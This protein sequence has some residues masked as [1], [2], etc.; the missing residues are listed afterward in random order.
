MEIEEKI[1]AKAEL[2]YNEKIHNIEL[3]RQNK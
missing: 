2:E 1:N 3:N